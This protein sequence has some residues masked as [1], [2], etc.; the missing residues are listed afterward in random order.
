[1]WASLKKI[2][3]FVDTSSKGVLKNNA[4]KQ[5]NEL[6]QKKEERDGRGFLRVKELSL[7]R[8]TQK[9]SF[10]DICYVLMC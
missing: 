5:R 7:L 4:S 1:V 9:L 6:N 10:E 8:H 2:G 3:T